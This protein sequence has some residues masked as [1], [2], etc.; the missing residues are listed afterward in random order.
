MNIKKIYI[1]TD[2]PI[3]MGMA[4]AS[5]IFSY[6]KGFLYHKIPCE[7]VVFR[8]TESKHKIMNTETN[9]ESENI[10]F[11]YLFNTTVKSEYFFKRRIDN[12]I[13]IVKLFLFSVLIVKYKS[14]IIYYAPYTVPAVA[15]KLAKVFNKAIIL[16]EKASIQQYVKKIITYFIG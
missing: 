10:K 8:K 9:G 1:I 6:A 5:R 11:R 4:Q 3:P 16:K 7:I 15:L 13:G 14:A 2:S 12:F